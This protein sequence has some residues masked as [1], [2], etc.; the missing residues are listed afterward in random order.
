MPQR[1]ETQ[2]REVVAKIYDEH[3]QKLQVYAQ[4]VLSGQ[5]D[6]T[7][8]SYTLAGNQTLA[9]T[10]GAT[11]IT[12][13]RKGNYTWAAQ[14]TGTSVKLQALGPDGATWLD[15]ATLSAPGIFAGEIR[16]GANAQLRIYN[17]N[18]TSVSGIYSSLS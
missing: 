3:V 16:I 13:V 2:A 17:P 12:G 5:S 10:T 9:A 14:F 15:V 4:Q 6:G 8:A 11:P 1:L 18:G 7:S